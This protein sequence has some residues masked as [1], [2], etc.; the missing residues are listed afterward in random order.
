MTLFYLLTQNEILQILRFLVTP[1]HFPLNKT[2]EV[3]RGWEGSP[4]KELP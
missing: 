2:E 3:L 1:S 4:K